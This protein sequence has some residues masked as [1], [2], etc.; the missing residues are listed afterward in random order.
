MCLECTWNGLKWA[1][2]S[3]LKSLGCLG[4]H[5]FQP[6]FEREWEHTEQGS[7]PLDVREREFKVCTR[8]YA[9]TAGG[10]YRQGDAS[11]F[12]RQAVERVVPMAPW[13]MTPLPE[14]R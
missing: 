10:W 4:R 14:Q 1:V 7:R 2:K 13:W 5:D 11:M 3:K 12:D 8:C 9:T 6:I